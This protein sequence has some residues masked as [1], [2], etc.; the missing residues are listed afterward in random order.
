MQNDSIDNLQKELESQTKLINIKLNDMRSAFCMSN[1]L[2]NIQE[3]NFDDGETKVVVNAK[4]FS[5][6]KNNIEDIKVNLKYLDQDFKN[7]LFEKKKEITLDAAKLVEERQTILRNHFEKNLFSELENCKSEAVKDV[8]QL[9]YNK[10]LFDL[11]ENEDQIFKKYLTFTNQYL[12]EQD[13]NVPS[14]RHI[15]GSKLFKDQLLEKFG[16]K[17]FFQK[18]NFD[19]FSKKSIF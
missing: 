15:L 4:L 18:K 14:R 2:Q 19:F 8:K 1:K 12:M 9:L 3:I 10:G 11:F 16:K 5:H 7:E 13:G 6:I 17:I